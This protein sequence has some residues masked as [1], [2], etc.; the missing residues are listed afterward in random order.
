MMQCLFLFALN[1]GR[2]SS[3]VKYICFDKK[4]V[5]GNRVEYIPVWY[6][7][8]HSSDAILWRILTK[9]TQKPF[10]QEYLI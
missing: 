8:A 1:S 2:K 7:Q 9:F 4:K 6:P 5:S 10:F 3:E